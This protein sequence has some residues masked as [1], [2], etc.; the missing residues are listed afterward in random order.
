MKRISERLS[1]RRNHSMQKMQRLLSRAGLGSLGLVG[2]FNASCQ[3]AVTCGAGTRLDEATNTCV[4][5]SD[6]DFNIIVDDFSV[7][8]F[9]FTNVDVPEQMQPGFPDER[10]FT[11][12]NNGE[13]DWEVV[14]MRISLVRVERTIDELRELIDDVGSEPGCDTDDDCGVGT[15]CEPV[16]LVCKI[17]P[18]VIGAIY[19]DDLKAGETREIR[20][21]LSLPREFA[22]E[23][24]Y[25]LMFSVNEVIMKRSVET[26]AEGNENTF[27]YEDEEH[28]LERGVD[29]MTRAATLYAPSTVIVGVPDKPN[30]RVLFA[31]LDNSSFELG[32]EELPLFNVSDRLSAQGKSTRKPVTKT[33]ELVLPGHAIDVAGKDLGIAHFCPDGA[34]LGADLGANASPEAAALLEPEPFNSGCEAYEAA[35]ELTTWVYDDDRTFKL[36]TANQAGDLFDTYVYEPKCGNEECTELLTIEN[37][38][39]ADSNL[40]LFLKREDR[41]LLART[42]RLP[43]QNPAL[44]P[45][46]L[47]LPGT[48]RMIVATDPTEPEYEVNDAPLLADNVEEFDIVFMAPPD[49]GDADADADADFEFEPDS[50]ETQSHVVTGPGPYN[51]TQY[52]GPQWAWKVGG[53]WI[54]ASAGM[55]NYLSHAV[56]DNIRV[57]TQFKADNYARLN[58]LKNNF[59]IMN[60]AADVDFGSTRTSLQQNKASAKVVFL[61]TTYLD[62]LFQPGQCSTEDNF[63]TCVIYGNEFSIENDGEKDPTKKGKN[64]KRVYTSWKRTKSFHFMAGPLPFEISISVSM[65]LGLNVQLAFVRDFSVANEQMTGLQASA[66]PIFSAGGEAFGGLS[67]GILKA[68]IWGSVKFV[69]ANFQPAVTLGVLTGRDSADTCW[70]KANGAIRIE[71]PFTLKVLEAAIDV[72]VES[73]LCAC[74]PWAGCA[75]WNERIFSFEIYKF[76]P[77]ATKTWNLWN[78]QTINFAPPEASRCAEWQMPWT[79][80]V[81]RA[82][83]YPLFTFWGNTV[84]GFE[85]CNNAN[86]DAAGWGSIGDAPSYQKVIDGP[87]TACG[88]AY[89]D[90]QW[91]TGDDLCFYWQDSPISQ[92]PYACFG[93]SGGSITGQPVQYCGGTTVRFRADSDN[94]NSRGQIRVYTK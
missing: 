20:H 83:K 62:I 92:A 82:C 88:T 51:T 61:G 22:D 74:W 80:T 75:C 90:A 26:D 28:P 64:T 41:I 17:N 52:L 70:R 58:A 7:G 94:L 79:W 33:F 5:A 8:D 31:N 23:G 67:V 47:E 56:V 42:A 15:Y 60:I 72:G 86:Y 87:S 18:E 73:N 11:I 53:E 12:T 59:D 6:P 10:T 78:P 29:P 66:G 35:P 16:E 46:V 36:W 21:T 1:A 54:G 89:I 76:G 19:I 45:E 91:G 9:A 71:G 24:L 85:V 48:L 77:V 93:A 65:G 63:E 39:G 69:E 13:E 57:A 81:P 3:D 25:G 55:N 43:E 40:G 2:M 49:T 50:E 27:Y 32:N 14:F 30:L 84:Y 4:A 38:V 34:N 68:G 44:D 37:D